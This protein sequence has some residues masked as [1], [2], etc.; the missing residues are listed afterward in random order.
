MMDGQ[1]WD[2]FFGITDIVNEPMTI[3]LASFAVGILLLGTCVIA[4]ISV[5]RV[6]NDQLRSE[7][8]RRMRAWWVLG[9]V[10]GGVILLGPLMTILGML[11]LGVLCH[12]EFARATGLFREKLMSGSVVFCL[13][14]M[15]LAILDNWYNFFAALPGLC[16]VAIAMAAVLQ[17]RTEG[18]L[19]RYALAAVSLML[20]GYGLGHLSYWA[21]E[22]GYRAVLLLVVLCV[23]LND[24]FAFTCGKLFGKRKLIVNVSPNKT[25]G[26]AAGAL[27]L[28][29]LLFV[30]LGRKV[31]EGMNVGSWFHLLILGILISIAG[32]MGDLFISAIKRD[33]GVKDMGAILPGHGGIL[34][35]FDSLVLIGPVLSHYV[36]YF[37]KVDRETGIRIL[38]GGL[39][40]G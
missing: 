4:G 31:F 7:L 29:S 17:N 25:I 11:I 2:R 10:I 15:S 21:N 28:T 8:W 38:T 24:V 20:F 40:G 34:D 14:L 30:L 16:L 19:Q 33:I 32:Q 37:D 3:V 6:G 9:F 5:T 27:L 36:W 22:S 13:I 23:E 1:N 26:G 35:R 18:F 39:L 12:A